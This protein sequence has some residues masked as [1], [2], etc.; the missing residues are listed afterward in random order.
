M[1]HTGLLRLTSACVLA[2]F[3]LAPAAARADTY[4]SGPITFIVAWPPGGGSDVS[5]RLLTEAASKKLGVPVV[6]INR[7]GAGGAIGHR[8]I[9]SARTFIT[10]TSFLI[11]NPTISPS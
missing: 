6:V 9:V 5:M 7:P 2:L 3:A 8:E 10:A 11:P 4:P 1:R